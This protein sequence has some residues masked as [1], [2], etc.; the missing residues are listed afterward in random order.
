LNHDGINSS[1]ELMGPEPSKVLIFAF[2]IFVAAA[3]YLTIDPDF[4][5]LS[6]WL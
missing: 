3:I 1:S 4:F 5:G 2:V 6:N